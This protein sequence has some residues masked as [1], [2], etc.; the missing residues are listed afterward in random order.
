MSGEQNT[1]SSINLN[2]DFL[3]ITPL[4]G[5]RLLE[6]SG[7]GVLQNSRI[8]DDGFNDV[9]W[10]DT[11]SESDKAG[12]LVAHGSPIELYPGKKQKL[13]FLIHSNIG[14]TAEIARTASIKLFYRP[15][16]RTI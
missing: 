11:G 3:Q 15:R 10:I 2:L 16:R 4:D 9:F 6:C 12:Y 1:G 7:Y 8:V 13:H 5:W 14:N